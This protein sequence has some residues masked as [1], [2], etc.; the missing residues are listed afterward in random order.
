MLVMLHNEAPNDSSTHG[1]DKVQP[2]TAKCMFALI[3]HIENFLT[4]VF[5]LY[6]EG[7]VHSRYKQEIIGD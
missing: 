2:T 5:V 4:L 6:Y 3:Q 7:H 1:S